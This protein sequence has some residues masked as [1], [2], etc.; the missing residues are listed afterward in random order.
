MI[1]ASGL[2]TGEYAANLRLPDFRKPSLINFCESGEYFC[3][4]FIRSISGLDVLTLGPKIYGSVELM[5]TKKEQDS[6]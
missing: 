2:K 3:L 1:T 5:I 4:A 6:C